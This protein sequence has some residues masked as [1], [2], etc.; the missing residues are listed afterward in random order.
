ME[1]GGV[2]RFGRKKGQV[3]TVAGTIHL[4]SVGGSEACFQCGVA[5]GLA[6]FQCF[7]RCHVICC[8]SDGSFGLA[9]RLVLGCHLEFEGNELTANLMILTVEDFDCN[10]GC[11]SVDY[12]LNYC[13]DNSS[14]LH[15]QSNGLFCLSGRTVVLEDDTL[16]EEILSQAHRIKYSSRKQ[17][18]VQRLED[19]VLWKGIKRSIYRCLQVLSLS[20]D[21]GRAS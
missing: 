10:L 16:K 17:Q 11:R 4:I 15:Y 13:G 14:G 2:F 20:T 21:Q 1:F 8:S 12:L 7:P 3:S 5:F 19:S 9:K 6:C 18:D